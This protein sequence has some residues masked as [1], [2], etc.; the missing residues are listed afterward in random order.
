MRAS[1]RDFI[2]FVVAGAAVAGCPFKQGL[3]AAL[4]DQ[5]P[6]VEV[7]AKQICHQLRDGYAFSRPAA[8]KQHDI[9]IV[10]G[11]VSGLTAAYLLRHRNCLVLEK[12][13]HWGGNAYR[14]DYNGMAFATGAAF[15]EP[16][17]ASGLARE[18]GLEKL[19]VNNWDGSIVRGEFVTDTWGE[20]LD[21]LP[22]SRSLRDSFK[23]FRQAMLA[24]DVEKRAT[25]LDNVRFSDFMKGYPAEIQQWW[26]AFGPS[27][28]GCVSDETAAGH[29]VL[30]LQAMA[31]DNR[32][33]DRF[34]WPGGL[35]AIT[36]R[37]AE[38]LQ[39]SMGERMVDGATIVSVSQEKHAAHVTYVRGG[40]LHT[41]AAKVVIMAIPKFITARI[42]DGVPAK[43]CEAMR[44]IHYQPYAVV[45]LIFDKPV[46]NRGY[47]TW[48][49]GNRFTDFIVADW[50]VRNKPGYVQ[51]YN[52]L[53]CQVPL[54]EHERGLL[55]NREGA[56]KIAH[57]VLR[58]FQKLFPGSNVNPREVY[59]YSRGHPL[60]MST[61]GLYTKVM[62]L[63]R[64]PM[65]R[66]FF[67]NTDSE[68]PESTTGTAIKAAERSV[69]QAENR[70]AGRVPKA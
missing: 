67:A 16:E 44:E 36:E 7:E 22:Y 48:C 52:I 20:G 69:R 45:N 19:A 58:D 60:F 38:V 54:R 1:R 8:T 17:V 49:P 15:T 56:I 50:V 26:D 10:G 18:L 9:V 4:D 14:V 2:K 41:V 62:P 39:S 35:G 65:D 21:H 51:K 59:I 61:P 46:F 11:G 40:A 37:L 29:G 3:L 24:I 23:K 42:V 32:V 13:W 12:E 47:D 53:T 70:M 31:A 30:A 5:A 43:Q 34:S 55:L 64:Q 28:W 57:Q 6:R 66:I 68:G 27:N 33:D 25:E 63:V